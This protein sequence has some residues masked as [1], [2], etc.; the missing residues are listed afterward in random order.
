MRGRGIFVSESIPV[1]RKTAF[2][3]SAEE[4]TV[5][6]NKDGT[7]VFLVT[8]SQRKFDNTSLLAGFQVLF[9]HQNANPT[10]WM[11]GF[12]NLSD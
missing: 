5:E 4:Q 12:T 10:S 3:D 6:S 2:N 11:E 7:K 8:Q 1:D 9:L